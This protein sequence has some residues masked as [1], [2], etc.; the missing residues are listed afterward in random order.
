[1]FSI[2]EIVI[3]GVGIFSFGYITGIIIGNVSAKNYYKPTK[4]EYD[5]GSLKSVDIY[6][7]EKDGFKETY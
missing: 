5:C 4:K 3:V 6:A 7:V 2:Y 1:M